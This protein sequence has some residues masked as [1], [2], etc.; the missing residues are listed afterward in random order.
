MEVALGKDREQ[1]IADSI[2]ACER[3]WATDK[4]DIFIRGR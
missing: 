1:I 4:K 3:G 2:N